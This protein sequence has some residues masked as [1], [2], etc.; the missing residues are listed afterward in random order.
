IAEKQGDSFHI[1]HRDRQA[2]K[3]GKGGINRHLITDDGLARALKTL[4]EFKQKI[5]TAGK[6]QIFALGTSALRNAKNGSAIVQE[7]KKE[8]G[9]EVTVISGDQEAEFICFGVRAALHLGVEKSLIMDIGGG[10]VEF[11]IAN[12]TTIFWKR[13]FEIG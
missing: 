1:I 13:S 9:I 7:I 11:I 12:N 5:N 10:S 2:V 6:A 3:I 8:T 4:K